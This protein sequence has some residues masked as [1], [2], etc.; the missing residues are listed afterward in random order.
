MKKILTIFILVIFASNLYGGWWKNFKKSVKKEWKEAGKKTDHVSTVNVNTTNFWGVLSAQAGDSMSSKY[1]IYQ[2]PVS[3]VRVNTI[4]NRIARQTGKNINFRFGILN[5]DI[6]NA[7][8]FP[9]GQIY[10]TKGL[11]N[12]VKTDDELA[13]VIGHECAHVRNRDSEKALVKNLLFLGTM[14]AVLGNSKSK[15]QWAT[16]VQS[17]TMM[18]F[19][20][21]DE[22]EADYTGMEYA[23]GAGYNPSGMTEF[24]QQLQAKEGSSSAV[25]KGIL[26]FV[27]T[28]PLTEDRVK[29]TV[30][31]AAE[32]MKRGR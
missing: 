29:R 23:Y 5:T 25:E 27:S 9:D 24:L 31:T 6:I 13:C 2:D 12:M 7:F 17:L 11:L 1:G 15:Q 20:R 26:K 4:G 30:A 3:N 22:N 16:L 10:V 19:S 8:A 21:S 28:H 32:L 18:K 14:Q